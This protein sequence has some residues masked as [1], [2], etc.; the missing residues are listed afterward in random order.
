[1]CE[2]LQSSL[3]KVAPSHPP[4]PP[5]LCADLS[6]SAFSSLAFR[7]ALQ[8]RKGPSLRSR[9]GIQAWLLPA[10]CPR[11]K[12]FG[13]CSISWQDKEGGVLGR[14]GPWRGTCPSVCNCFL[15][16]GETA[17]CFLRE[18]K[19]SPF[20]GTDVRKESAPG[21]HS[22]LTL[23]FTVCLLSFRLVPC[24]V[25]AA[26]PTFCALSETVGLPQPEREFSLFPV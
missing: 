11:M 6:R 22:E 12:V 18:K 23:T 25:H 20:T 10:A 14:P 3:L 1:M 5:T 19:V 13:V 26:C 2:N 24:A 15:F 8:K 17:L 9:A 4:H 16:L 7:E 21:P